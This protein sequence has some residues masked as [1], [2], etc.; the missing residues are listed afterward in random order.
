[1]EQNGL[2]L[3][4]YNAPMA[5]ADR[6]AVQHAPATDRRKSCWQKRKARLDLT[7]PNSVHFTRPWRTGAMNDEI[8]GRLGRSRMQG[9][10][11]C[12]KSFA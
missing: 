6:D 10:L 7:W 3:P 5:D 4:L 11:R 2:E 12:S 8:P 9:A 1:M